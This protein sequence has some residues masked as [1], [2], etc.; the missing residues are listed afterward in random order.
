MRPF[1]LLLAFW[2][3]AACAQAQDSVEVRVFGAEG[4]DEATAVWTDANGCILA[5]ETTSAIS[6]A[7]GQA[8]WAP[9]GPVGRKGF[10][11]VLD[12]A[13][14]HVWSFAFA[15]D[16]DA[17]MGAPSTLA[18]RDVVRTADSTAWVLYDAPRNGQWMGHLM[19]VNADGGAVTEF[20]LGGN[21]AVSTCALVP[22]GGETFVVVGH[23]QD[24]AAPSTMPNGLM[25]G[26]WTG[27]ASPPGWAPIPGTEDMEAVCA[28]WHEDTLYVAVH[29]NGIPEAP[30]AVLIITADNG[31]P[32]VVGAA[33]IVD[34]AVSLSGIT[35]GPLGVAWSGTVE[36]GDGTLDAIYGK[37]EDSADPTN[38]DAWSHAWMVETVGDEDRPGRGILWTGV[39]LQCAGQITTEGDEGSGAIVQRRFGETGAW[40]GAH[41]FGGT[42]DEDVRD[43]ARDDQGRLYVVGSSSSWTDLNA[44]NGSHDAVLF[45]SSSF[46]LT[47]DFAYGDAAS[48]LP[49]DLAFVGVQGLSPPVSRQVTAVRRG[50]PM[51]VLPG[52]D[53]RLFD[54]SGAQVA[55]G[56]GTAPAPGNTGLL[57]LS[58][59]GHEGLAHRWIWVL[60]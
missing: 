26:L 18:V 58:T 33:P 37:L 55:A 17:P 7:E 28:D 27:D 51:P 34:P 57:R 1:L 48:L 36:S 39:I 31:N 15:G 29:R 4:M 2:C 41:I 22:A 32:Q 8:T 13:L 38:P 10:I 59:A 47:P 30:A 54:V 42:G 24:E 35:A 14:N 23:R 16:P 20:D 6:M 53:W 45:R 5:G 3:S 46:E 43:M 56:S 44:A 25:A 52:E 49:I 60:D 21:G 9:D 50:S 12:T 11:A 19:G 40:F